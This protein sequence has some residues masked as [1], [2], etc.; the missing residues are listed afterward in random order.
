MSEQ[1]NFEKAV[2]EALAGL[3]E[4]ERYVLEQRYGYRGDPV[5]Q[6]DLAAE[7]NI[8]R[9][10]VGQIEN[11]AIRKIRQPYPRI[12]MLQEYLPTVVSH[13]KDNFYSRFFIKLFRLK[14]EHILHILQAG[15]SKEAPE[16]L[17]EEITP[18]SSIECLELSIRSFNGL[19]RAGVHTVQDLMNLSEEDLSKIPNLGKKSLAEIC[20][21]RSNLNN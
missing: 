19:I 8:S 5:K 18:S 20:E 3:S 11:N 10:R 6:A 1:M 2:A 17:P 13:E 14:P 4:R 12:K 21:K 16:Q 9:T 15:P 7:L